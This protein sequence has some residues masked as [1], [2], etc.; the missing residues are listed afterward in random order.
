MEI[1]LK[2]VEPRKVRANQCGDWHWGADGSLLVS[3]RND[4]SKNTQLLIALHEFIEAILCKKAG[5]SDA[6]VTGF[7]IAFELER[8]A[9]K[10][11]EDDENGDDPRAPYHQEHINATAMEMFMCSMLGLTWK[12]HSKEI[13]KVN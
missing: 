6:Q 8:E 13:E 4:L 12:E 10:H 5:I 3:V 11:K 7:D 2:S 9:G 1:T